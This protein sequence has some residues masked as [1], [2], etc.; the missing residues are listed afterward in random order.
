[1]WQLKFFVLF[2]PNN[3]EQAATVDVGCLITAP[4]TNQYKKIKTAFHISQ[5]FGTTILSEGSTAIS[6]F[7]STT[8]IEMREV[9]KK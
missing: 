3:T 4:M 7:R 2:C 6:E 9:L 5:N 1:M 8:Y